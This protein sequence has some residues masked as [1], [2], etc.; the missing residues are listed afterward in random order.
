LGELSGSLHKVGKSEVGKSR[1]EGRAGQHLL[2]PFSLF[3]RVS[4][5]KIMRN[6]RVVSNLLL[7]PHFS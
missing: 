4:I 7:I 5:T 3:K 2:S 1:E 6:E